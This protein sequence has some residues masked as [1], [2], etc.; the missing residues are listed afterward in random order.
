MKVLIAI[1]FMML[2]YLS[3]ILVF[4]IYIIEHP[5]QLIPRSVPLAL[6]GWLILVTMLG[7]TLAR[8]AARA[9]VATETTVERK[10][11]INYGRK[12]LKIGMFFYSLFLLNGIRA[13]V[14]GEIPWKPAIVGIAVDILVIAGCWICLK[15]LNRFSEDSSANRGRSNEL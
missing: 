13:I 7:L 1:G 9:Q 12:G 2:L 14:Q 6:F 4:V 10:R 3:G 15:R 11:R 8:R 5:G